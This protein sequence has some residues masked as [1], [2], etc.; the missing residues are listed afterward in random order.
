LEEVEAL[1]LLVQINEDR[2][3]AGFPAVAS[4]DVLASE[5]VE[6]R[7]FFKTVLRDKL[8]QMATES[9]VAA[10]TN[11][12]EVVTAKGTRQAP[13]LLDDLVDSYE[14][15]TKQFLDKEAATADQLIATIRKA[16]ADKAPP[17]K[18]D[19]Q[20][21]DLEHVIR[22]WRRVAQPIHLSRMARGLEHSDSVQLGRAVRSLAVDLFNE[23]DLLAVSERLSKLLNEVFVEV[24]K[25]R[26]TVEKDLSDLR[27]IRTR[28]DESSKQTEEARRKWAQD[29]YFEVELGLLFK[30]KLQISEHGIYYGNLGLKLD[31]VTV[32]RW[33]GT[34]H[35]VNGMPTGTTY[36]VAFGNEQFCPIVKLPNERTFVAVTAKL[37]RAVGIEI[38]DRMLKTI[39]DGGYLTFP[40][41]NIGDE[42]IGLTPYRKERTYFPWS[43]V[44]IGTGPGYFAVGPRSERH[45][46]VELSYLTVNNVHFLEAI[47]QTFFRDPKA[48]RLRELVA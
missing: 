46:Q 45:R 5:L 11:A 8:D 9:L 10:V 31:Q 30:K 21:A 36:E 13:V 32:A 2:A 23:H 7:R 35:W 41:V 48:R 20:V 47:L 3:V 39:K 15:E 18:I 29:I 27:D 42:G 1:S 12:L 19:A 43:E 25:V 24:P 40:R 6:R 4:D 34:R 33:G 22:N 44:S 16:A 14:V 28:R 17:A 38:I 26:D 37:W